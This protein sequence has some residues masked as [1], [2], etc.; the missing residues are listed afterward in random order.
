MVEH[1]ELVHSATLIGLHPGLRDNAAR[2]A[3]RESDEAWCQLLLREGTRAFVD[4]W[5]RQPL[6][7]TQTR[8]DPAVL[9]EQRRRRL[10]H[11]PDGLAWALRSLGLAAMPDYW[12]SLATVR[13]PV[14]LMAGCLDTKFVALARAAAKDLGCPLTLVEDTGHNIV[15]ERPEAVVS[16]LRRGVMT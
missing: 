3:R 14:H 15:L 2:R 1:P 12:Q 11:R 13:V 8:L 6:F 10:S 7:L 5:E 4:A 9:S 16:A